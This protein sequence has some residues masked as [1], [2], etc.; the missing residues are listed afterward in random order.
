VMHRDVRGRRELSRAAA[1]NA[2]LGFDSLQSEGGIVT[3]VSV[4]EPSAAPS[5]GSPITT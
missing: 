3:M 4:R 5:L 2:R 1:L